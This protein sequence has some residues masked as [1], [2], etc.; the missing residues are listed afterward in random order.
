MAPESRTIPINCYDKER[1][2]IVNIAIVKQKI[3]E[4]FVNYKLMKFVQFLKDVGLLSDEQYWLIMYGTKNQ[5]YLSL[6]KKGVP[7]HL[8]IKLFNDG[9]IN[10]ISIHDTG[11]ITQ[12][13]EFKCYKETVDDITKF[14]INKYL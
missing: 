12:S 10:N 8:L 9:Q 3:E 5:K 11:T 2:E 6:M 4:D 1:R 13:S 14:E 7:V